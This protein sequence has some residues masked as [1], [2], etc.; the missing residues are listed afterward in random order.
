MLVQVP[1][2]ALPVLL[3]D[4]KLVDRLEQRQR[5][6]DPRRPWGGR[7]EDRHGLDKYVEPNALAWTKRRGLLALDLG[8][9]HRKSPGYL[10]VDQYARDGVDI[11]ATLPAPLDLPDD[12]VGLL[13]AVDFLEPCPRRFH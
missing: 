11:I 9:A 13:R 12:S 5:R 4:R 1:L 10:G 8:A 2:V 7:D 3:R 6:P